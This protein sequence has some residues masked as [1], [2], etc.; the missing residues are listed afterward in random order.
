MS[1]EEAI[2]V[3][4]ARS[5]E[6]IVEEGGSQAWVLDAAHARRC[7]WLVC[8]QNRHNANDDFSDATEAHGS[9][10][11]VGKVARVVKAA[12][13]ERGGRPRWLI[14]I[15]EFVRVDVPDFWGHERNPVRYLS[16]PELEKK[17][18]KLDE[19]VFEP[20]PDTPAR[21]AAP[22]AVVGLTIAEAR[23]GLAATFGVEPEAVE[24]TI[25]G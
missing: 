25:R 17:G 2:V 11:L 16:R 3:F 20:M 18:I 23:K 10:F 6:R 21:P 12:E 15:S 7:S 1:Q 4:T 22:S 9:A 19:L 24:I 8:T 14:T 13:T 5:P